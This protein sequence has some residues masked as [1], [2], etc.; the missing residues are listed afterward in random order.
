MRARLAHALRLAQGFAL[1]FVRCNVP[2][3][4]ASVVARLKAALPRPIG[5][6]DLAGKSE[7]YPAVARAAESLPDDGVLFIYGLEAHLPSSDRERA[8]Q[9]LRGLN[10]RRAAYQRLARPLVFWLPEYALTLLAREAPDFYDWNSGVFELTV[11]EPL[12]E[13]VLAAAAAI[14]DAGAFLSLPVEEKESRL[15]LLEG[16]WEEYGEAHPAE[17]RARLQIARQ[18]GGLYYSLGRYGE[19]RRW[20]GEAERPARALGARW[21]QA[22]VL[23][24]LGMLAQAQGDYPEARRLYEESLRIKEQ[25]GDRAGVAITLHQLGMLAQAQGD[26]PEA[27]RL[28]E[29]SLRLAEQLGDR[30]GVAKYLHQL[31]NAGSGPGRLPRSPAALRAGG[32][33]LPE[34]GGTPGTGG[35]PAP[36]GDA[37][38]GPGRLPR[39][40]A[41]L[42]GEPAPC[43][44]TGRPGRGG[45]YPAPYG[46]AGAGPGRLPRS[47]AALRA[48][49][50]RPSGATGRTRERAAVL[51]QLGNLAYLQGD[52]PEARRLYEASLRIKEQLGDRAGMAITLHQLG[53]LAQDQGDYPEARRLYEQ[54]AETFRDLG[55]LR[56]QAAVLHQLGNLAYLQGDYPE[57]R[58]LYEE[59][60]RIKEQLGDR[61]GVA[62]TTA[63]LALLEEAEGHLPRALELITR[64]EATFAQMGSPYREQTR[65]VRER[66]RARLGGG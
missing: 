57:A 28:Y 14:P 46:H 30:A 49:R 20:L 58:R 27:R 9:T 3:Y 50:Q 32:R 6:V 33:D 19:A 22:A 29:E 65:R 4:R 36:A 41:A 42:R 38:A 51:H 34:P 53:I 12:R 45:K 13:A 8:L 11:P 37:G 23:H 31:G 44:A 16:L 48:E 62:I 63:Q 15:R 60:L 55:A 59:S 2:L 17:R 18:L 54:A 25:L 5:E 39:S 1:F 21:E 64:A 61:A 43:G 52:Y 26:Y 7:V 35:S 40:P 56:E 24:Q 10:W 47:P 66:I